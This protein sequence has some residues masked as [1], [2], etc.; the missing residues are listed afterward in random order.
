[1][2]LVWHFPLVSDSSLPLSLFFWSIVAQVYR[3]LLLDVDGLCRALPAS[4]PVEQFK[5]GV[6][7]NVRWAVSQSGVPPN[8]PINQAEGICG[9]LASNQTVVE[10]NLW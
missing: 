6:R 9:L 10:T 1:M 2:A 8:Q 5:E 4:S 7:A 3:S